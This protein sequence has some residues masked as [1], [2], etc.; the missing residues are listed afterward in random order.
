MFTATGSTTYFGYTWGQNEEWV[1][2]V[3]NTNKDFI[4][5]NLPILQRNVTQ[6]IW[7]RPNYSD[8]AYKGPGDYLL[9]LKRYTGASDN[10]TGEDAVLTVTLTEPLPTPIP[11]V[12]TEITSTPNPTSEITWTPYP[13][14]TPSPT[15]TKT[16]TK[17]LS[18]SPT[19]SLRGVSTEESDD[20]AIS[21]IGSSSAVLSYSTNLATIAA[22]PDQSVK[23]QPETR[24]SKA[25]IFFGVGLVLCS[26]GL[27]YLRLKRS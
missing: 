1:N 14:K 2:Y 17:T 24:Q 25:I 20:A 9:K 7:V 10:S 11:T 18:P 6:K 8:S 26:G 16:P 12:T 21:A 4:T 15:S 3:S 5:L 23:N 19:S 27:L 22:I 13:T